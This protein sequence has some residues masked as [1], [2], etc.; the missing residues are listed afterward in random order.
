MNLIRKFHSKY[1][2]C[3]KLVEHFV[4]PFSVLVWEMVRNLLDY[5]MCR[6]TLVK[7]MGWYS[8]WCNGRGLLNIILGCF[9]VESEMEKIVKTTVERIF[10]S[11]Y[12]ERFL[13]SNSGVMLLTVHLSEVNLIAS[14]KVKSNYWFESASFSQFDPSDYFCLYK[15]IGNLGELSQPFRVSFPYFFLVFSS[16]LRVIFLE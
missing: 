1:H 11:D 8:K 2:T 6:I 14:S 3:H 10:I 15:C 16:S 5:G 9:V 7:G 13:R 12:V 4:G